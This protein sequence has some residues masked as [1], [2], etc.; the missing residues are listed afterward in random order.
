VRPPGLETA[1]FDE[2]GILAVFTAKPE[3]QPP[4]NGQ[5]NE[6]IVGDDVL[7]PRDEATHPHLSLATVEIVEPLARRS[8]QTRSRRRGEQ[9]QSKVHCAS[10][11]PPPQTS[12]TV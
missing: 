6:S 4:W 1:E 2:D 12:P 8:G 11:A 9:G 7:M 3:Y 10:T 5:R